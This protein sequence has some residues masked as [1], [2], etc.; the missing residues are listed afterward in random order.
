MKLYVYPFGSG[1]SKAVLKVSKSS[2]SLYA[3]RYIY[4]FIGT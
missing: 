1:A 4:R 3:R 2:I